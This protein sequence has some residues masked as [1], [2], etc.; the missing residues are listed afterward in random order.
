MGAKTNCHCMVNGDPAAST[1]ISVKNF[2][3]PSPTNMKVGTVAR[4]MNWTCA[5][6][7]RNILFAQRED[8][9]PFKHE[10][11]DERSDRYGRVRRQRQEEN[12]GVSVAAAGAK[13]PP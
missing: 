2:G 10:R 13:L 6:S 8:E 3:P 4:E 11:S 7:G 9:A 5:N 12:C 1:S